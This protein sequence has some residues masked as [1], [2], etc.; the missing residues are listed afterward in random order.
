MNPERINKAMKLSYA[1]LKKL[2]GFT[3][4][5]AHIIIEQTAKA[6]REPAKMLFAVMQVMGYIEESPSGGFRAAGTRS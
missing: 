6:D 3:A 5:E 2:A 4:E 1:K